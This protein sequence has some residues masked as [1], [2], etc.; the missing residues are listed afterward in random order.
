M[1]S[2]I[3]YMPFLHQLSDKIPGWIE[4]SHAKKHSKANAR[5]V[6]ELKLCN[7]NFHSF[8]LLRQHKRKEHGARRGS[9]AHTVDVTQLMGDVDDNRLKDE[10]ETCKHFFSGQLDGECETKSLQ[11]CHGYSGAEISVA[12]VKCCF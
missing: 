6:H 10:L 4:F 8:Y 5:V 9:I 7:K 1:I 11:I 12:K 3:P 2:W